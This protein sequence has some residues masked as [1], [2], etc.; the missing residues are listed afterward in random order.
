MESTNRGLKRRLG[1][2]RLRVRGMPAVKL[3][4][5]LKLTAWNILRAV[6]LRLSAQQT[7]E[8]FQAS[9]A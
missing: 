6:A 3:A 7:D 4:V 8:S 5:M 9:Y 1:L 2:K